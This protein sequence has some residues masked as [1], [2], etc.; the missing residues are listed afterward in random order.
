MRGTRLFSGG[1]LTE[2]RSPEK[3]TPPRD[4]AQVAGCRRYH[5][6]NGSAN[7]DA[8]RASLSDGHSSARCGVEARPT[9][10]DCASSLHRPTTSPATR[11]KQPNPRRATWPA[12]RRLSPEARTT[13]AFAKMPGQSWRSFRIRCKS[14]LALLRPGANELSTRLGRHSLSAYFTKL[15]PQ[16]LQVFDFSAGLVLARNSPRRHRSDKLRGE[17]CRLESSRPAFS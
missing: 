3:K 14:G 13:S 2:T 17:R 5:R 9:D 16:S 4:G 6:A 10:Q 7:L 1:Q 15:V 8:I 12:W 11:R